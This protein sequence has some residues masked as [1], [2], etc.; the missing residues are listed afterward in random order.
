ML[1]MQAKVFKT[2]FAG[3][4]RCSSIPHK[5]RPQKNAA[6]PEKIPPFE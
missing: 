2:F 4:Y 6:T 3:V 1:L 5:C